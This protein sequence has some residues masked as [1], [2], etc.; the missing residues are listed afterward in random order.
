MGIH[1]LMRAAMAYAPTSF[2]K[3]VSNDH[4]AAV[5]A[6]K[7]DKQHPRVVDFDLCSALDYVVQRLLK[8]SS[9]AIIRKLQASGGVIDSGQIYA[10]LEL[11]VR[12]RILEIAIGEMQAWAHEG[13]TVIGLID[14]QS[15]FFKR[16]TADERKKRTAKH[17]KKLD[18][19]VNAAVQAIN[20]READ[21][22]IGKLLR[23]VSQGLPRARRFDMRKFRPADIMSE[24]TLVENIRAG[25]DSFLSMAKAKNDI[26]FCSAI[27]ESDHTSGR[28]HLELIQS[29]ITVSGN[30]ATRSNDSDVLCYYTPE[31]G[32]HAVLYSPS[33]QSLIV[34]DKDQLILDL[35]IPWLVFLVSCLAAGSDY[36]RRGLYGL[37]LE[38]IFQYLLPDDS[39]WSDVRPW[40]DHSHSSAPW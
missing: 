6:E 37:G 21:S 19:A 35:G 25:K 36:T 39:V 22:H 4:A 12:D 32:Q 3:A 33:M 27:G 10:A 13:F 7:C 20:G 23:Q 2:A 1:G 34:F 38:R 5:V 30:I 8:R 18:R 26:V 16:E 40:E 17:Q 29:G 31:L 9:S 24:E 28:L 11:G 14:D 15:P